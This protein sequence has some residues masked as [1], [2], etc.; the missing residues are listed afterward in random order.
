MK[1]HTKI[2]LLGA[3]LLALGTAAI[4]QTSAAP[5]QAV[6]G[7]QAPVSRAD[8]KSRLEKQFAAADAN[9]DGVLSVE[10]RKAHRSQVRTDMRAHMF[11]R[12]DADQNGAISKAEFD[13]AH[14]HGRDKAG[15]R[16]DRRGHGAHGMMQRHQLAE[17][18]DKPIPR[19]TFVDAGL[20][21]FDRVDTDHD[22]KISAAERD[23][24][25]KAMRDRPAAANRPAPPPPGL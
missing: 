25:R 7:M 10:E 19:A 16:H 20:A 5:A 24:A 6:G 11:A 14:D 18:R 2:T 23:A 1:V 8:L 13:A 9:R 4:A 17:Y 21:R 22:G 3:G 15:K 12:L